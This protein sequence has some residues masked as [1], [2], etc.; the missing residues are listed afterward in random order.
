VVAAAG[1]A[2]APR[3][4]DLASAT[5]IDAVVIN[6]PP[7]S[8]AERPRLIAALRSIPRLRLAPC[9]ALAAR[10]HVSGDPS[11]ADVVAVVPK[12]VKRATLVAVLV[13]VCTSVSAVA[14]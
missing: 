14:S 12:P 9:V 5:P 6:P 8:N 1:V 3:R 10:L 13:K 2:D 7:P 11:C 4:L